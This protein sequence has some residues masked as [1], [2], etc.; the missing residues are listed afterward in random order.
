MR[1]TGLDAQ[2]LADTIARLQTARPLIGQNGELARTLAALQGLGIADFVK[3][4]YSSRSGPV[5]RYQSQPTSAAT[6][7]SDQTPG[8]DAPGKESSPTESDD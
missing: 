6:E 8:V 5:A 3:A 4:Q 2:T 7:A 1:R